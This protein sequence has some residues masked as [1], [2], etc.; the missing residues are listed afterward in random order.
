MRP[1]ITFRDARPK[2]FIQGKIRLHEDVELDVELAALIILWREKYRRF[3]D[4]AFTPLRMDVRATLQAL[5]EIPDS[6]AEKAVRLLDSHTHA[7][8]KHAAWLDYR[9]QFPEPAPIPPGALSIQQ[10]Y[11]GRVVLAISPIRLRDLAALALTVLPKNTGGAPRINSF[12]HFFACELAHHWMRINGT[13]P[14]V[15]TFA[16][17]NDGTPFSM[18]AAEMFSRVGVPRKDHTKVLK[19]AIDQLAK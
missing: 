10:V 19:L 4:R 18:W 6:G 8:I 7:C 3:K 5:A 11:A 2:R 1:K 16:S 12:D 13:E 17:D 14:T 15:E 9:R